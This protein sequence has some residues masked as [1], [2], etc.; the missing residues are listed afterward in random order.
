VYFNNVIYINHFQK[1]QS[2]RTKL[3]LSSFIVLFA[4]Y[5]LNA[6]TIQIGSGTTNTNYL[7]TTIPL[8]NFSYGYSQQI[9]G[10]QEFSLADGMAGNITKIRWMFPNPATVKTNYGDW[11]I[12]IGHTTKTEF[13]STTDWEPI[14]NL[15]QIFS[16]NIHTLP[17]PLTTDQWFEIE[18]STPF[19]YNGTDNI[20]VAVHE[21]TPGWAAIGLTIRTYASTPNSGIIYRNNNTNPDPANP[22]TANSRVA[23][24]PQLQFEGV[25]ASCVSPTDLTFTKTTLTSATLEWTSDGNLFDVVRT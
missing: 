9:V 21:K 16:G 3:L 4:T 20:V 8:Q 17:F 19:L 10:A 18:F 2:K 13:A 15:T 14:A 22:P 6:Q 5:T 12:W 11:D 23:I 24:L 1:N 25:M 7:S